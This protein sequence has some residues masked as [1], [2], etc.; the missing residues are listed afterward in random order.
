MSEAT[1]KKLGGPIGG[2][3]ESH[4]SYGLLQISKVTSSGARPLFGSS[5]KHSNTVRISIHTATKRR[6]DSSSEYYHDDK[7]LIEVEMS[8]SQFAEAITTLNHGTG[9]PVTLQ[10][11]MGKTMEACPEENKRAQHSREFKERMEKLAQ[12]IKAKRDELVATVDKAKLSKKAKEEMIMKY[13]V[14]VQEIEKNIPFFETQFNRQMDKTVTEAKAE[15]ESFITN[16]IQSTGLK[17]LKDNE[18]EILKL[19]D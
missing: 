16:A 14:L 4:E 6:S 1:K 17:A 11:I 8:A 9:T 15:V 13:N 5:I 10:K 7:Q 2:E 19:G 18:G 3:E 12:S